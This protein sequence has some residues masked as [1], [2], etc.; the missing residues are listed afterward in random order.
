MVEVGTRCWVLLHVALEPVGELAFG[1]VAEAGAF[2]AVAFETGVDVEGG[3]AGV[4]G[5]A[6]ETGCFGN[7]VY[8]D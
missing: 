7:A 8:V 3:L 2:A 4:F 1:A 5:A 6:Y